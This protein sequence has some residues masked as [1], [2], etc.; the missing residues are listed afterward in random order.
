M[1]GGTRTMGDIDIPLC[2]RLRGPRRPLAQ[3]DDLDGTALYKALGVET[4]ATSVE[5]KKARRGRSLECPDRA[6]R[7][8]SPPRGA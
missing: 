8:P 2:N 7:L 1:Q 4:G 3:V 6:S 5:I